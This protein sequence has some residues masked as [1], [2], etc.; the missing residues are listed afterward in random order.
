MRKSPA[1]FRESAR[2]STHLEI[3]GNAPDLTTTEWNQ[4]VPQQD[5]QSLL[6]DIA[7]QKIVLEA[8]VSL[9]I[10]KNLCTREEIAKRIEQKK[11]GQ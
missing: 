1:P 9:L 8:L 2:K 3:V 10:E 4:M 6:Q 11:M 7:T 5:V